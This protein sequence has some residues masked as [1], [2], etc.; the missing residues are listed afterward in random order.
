MGKIEPLKKQLKNNNNKD[1]AMK[2]H[3]TKKWKE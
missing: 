1:K 2:K 3:K